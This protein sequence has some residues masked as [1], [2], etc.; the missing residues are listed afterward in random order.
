MVPSRDI[1]RL[2]EIM[3][4]LRTPGSG[5]PWDLEQTYATIA[6]YTVEEAYEVADAIARG[7][8]GDLK[9]ELG[10]LLLQ[11][12][13]HARMAEEDGAFAFPDVVEAIT[14]KLVRRHPHVFGAARD[15]SPEAVKGLWAEIKA[16]E[17][18]EKAARRAAA[19]LPPD[20]GG[21]VL[22]GVPLPLPALTRALKLQEK[23]SRVGFDW[24][25]ARQ[26]LAKIREETDEVAEAL[27][28]HGLAAVRDEM[29]DLL[30]AVV[31]LA[32]HAGV[33]P[34]AALAG[35][36]DK[37]M[38]RFRFLEQALDVQGRTPEAASLDEMEALWQAAKQAE[39]GAAS[40]TGEASSASA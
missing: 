32:R 23:A 29:G 40:T 5:C 21:S 39:R 37:F 22:D 2:I 12:V 34:E 16:E 24:N 13:F 18:R 11:V 25:D 38:R 19:G 28:S 15:L 7:D 10:D 27:D 8:L 31:N 26:V 20:E 4:A 36:N 35:T 17:K 3:A 33:D 1:A 6:P 30:F 14:T 9:E